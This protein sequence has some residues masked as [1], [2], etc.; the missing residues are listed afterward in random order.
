MYFVKVKHSIGHILVMAGLIDVKWKGSALA[1][2]WVNYVTLTFDLTHD[3]D[4][5]FFKIRIWNSCIS[6]ILG[7]IDVKW[8]GSQS[9]GYWSDYATLPFELTY[10]IDIEFSG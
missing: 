10:D 5:G 9:I 6:G 8:K 2:Y 4:L 1:G 3:L 7:L